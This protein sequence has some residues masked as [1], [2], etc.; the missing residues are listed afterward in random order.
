MIDVPRFAAAAKALAGLPFAHQ[1]RTSAGLDC[2]GLVLAAL[3]EQ[4][5][6]VDAPAD[7]TTGAAGAI[8][9]D[10]LRRSPLLVELLPGE[11]PQAGELLAFR[12]RRDVQ[13]LAI[14]LGGGR[15]IHAIRD[16]GVAPVTIS[17]LWR[18]RLSARFG[19]SA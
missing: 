16:A 18:L 5:V 14:A 6:H 7:Y 2:A 4:G 12:I 1:G 11:E 3:A 13:H 15:M 10:V 19:W 9:L 8:L 17:P